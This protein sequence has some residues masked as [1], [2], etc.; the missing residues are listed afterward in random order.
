[1]ITDFPIEKVQPDTFFNSIYEIFKANPFSEFRKVHWFN[2]VL[3]QFENFGLTTYLINNKNNYK[4]SSERIELMPLIGHKTPVSLNSFCLIAIKR[5]YPVHF[6]TKYK[7]NDYWSHHGVLM[8]LKNMVN[9]NILKQFTENTELDNNVWLDIKR[10]TN[11]VYGMVN[12]PLCNLV[13]HD[14]FSP[15]IFNYE[16]YLSFIGLFD[17]DSIIA[18]DTDSVLLNISLEELRKSIDIEFGIHTN[19]QLNACSDIKSDFGTVNLN[20]FCRKHYIDIAY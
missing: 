19:F 2:T 5:L 4:R 17:R 7:D 11:M 20:K 13:L 6:V 14:K 1:M 15:Y 18:S 8:L 9:C 16:A 10:F 3:G 12:I